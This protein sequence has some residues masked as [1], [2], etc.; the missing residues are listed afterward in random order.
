[1]E[2]ENLSAG[3]GFENGAEARAERDRQEQEAEAARIDAMPEG[4][5]KEAAKRDFAELF[6]G[7]GSDAHDETLA[8]SGLEDGSTIPEGATKASP[9]DADLDRA[10]SAE[11]DA[12][13]TSEEG[14]EKDAAIEAFKAKYGYTDLDEDDG[15]RPELDYADRDAG[16]DAPAL[17]D[18]L[19]NERKVAATSEFI[20][21]SDPDIIVRAVSVVRAEVLLNTHLADYDL[22][23][24]SAYQKG[25]G[26]GAELEIVIALKRK[27]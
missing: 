17:R 13:L 14:P 21:D 16:G 27:G 2:Q 18:A 8:G 25:T 15:E 12:I 6:A 19:G 20:A 22:L 4:D 24:M 7:D 9:G 1:M 5:E 3:D 23:S 26:F 11:W 10:K